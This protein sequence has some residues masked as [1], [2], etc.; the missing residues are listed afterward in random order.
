LKK[1][2]ETASKM[3][4]KPGKGDGKQIKGKVST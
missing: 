2:E 1:F 3:A 4:T